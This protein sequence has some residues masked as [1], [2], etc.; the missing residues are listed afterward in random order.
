[1]T[2]KVVMGITTPM[3]NSDNTNREKACE[4][5]DMGLNQE[6][7]NNLLRL[8]ATSN[9]DA[10]DCDGCLTKISEFADV[11]L[12][13]REIPQA[14]SAVKNHLE[15]CPCCQDEFNALREA[16]TEIDK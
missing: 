7:I 6:Q 2:S 13:N 14:L 10:M 15:Q 9:N 3:K 16:L 1:M 12:L 5:S 11:H 8:V 4:K